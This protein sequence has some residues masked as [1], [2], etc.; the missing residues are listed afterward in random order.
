MKAYDI[1]AA[2]LLDDGVVFPI[3]L[4]VY[5]AFKGKPVSELEAQ[6]RRRIKPL[7]NFFPTS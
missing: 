2:Y 3:A 6:V 1:A 7:V 5:G 4:N